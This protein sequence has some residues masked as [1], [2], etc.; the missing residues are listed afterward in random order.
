MKKRPTIN[1]ELLSFYA[2]QNRSIRLPVKFKNKMLGDATL[3]RGVWHFRSWEDENEVTC[4]CYADVLLIVKYF[5]TNQDLLLIAL[6]HNKKIRKD[7]KI[8]YKNTEY[9]YELLCND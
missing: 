4:T 5:Y 1:K 6:H 8:M 9:N 3:I 7:Y 2:L